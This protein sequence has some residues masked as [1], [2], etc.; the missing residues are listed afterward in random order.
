MHVKERCDTKIDSSQV[1]LLERKIQITVWKAQIL[2]V[3]GVIN[4]GT[5]MRCCHCGPGKFIELATI[6]SFSPISKKSGSGEIHK[7]NMLLQYILP[8]VQRT[9]MIWK[10]VYAVLTT[11]LILNHGILCPPVCLS[12][13][14]PFNSSS[15]F[16]LPHVRQVWATTLNWA[17]C[18]AHSMCSF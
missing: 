6:L 1:S 8:C 9:I 18:L 14:E 12:V 4:A 7:R 2:S 13:L 11:N 3:C 5:K 10:N 17:L 16:L 15:D